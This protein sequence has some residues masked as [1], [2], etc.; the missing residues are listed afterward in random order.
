M[1]ACIR[2][3]DGVVNHSGNRHL[4]DIVERAQAVDLGRRNAFRSAL[5]LAALGFM[6]V[7]IAGC[8]G[9]ETSATVAS[10]ATTGALPKGPSMSG[11]KAVATSTGDTVVVPDGYTAHAIAK[12][13]DPLF[14]NSPEWRGD[15]SEDSQAQELQVGDNHDGIQYIGL[16]GED[17]KPRSDAGLLVINHEYV[18][19]EYLYAPGDDAANWLEP[20]TPDKARKGQAAHGLTVVE[21]RLDASG[22]WHTVLDSKYN[23]RIT[24]FSPMVVTGPAAGNPMLMTADDPTGMAVKGT[25]NNCGSG[26]TPWHTVLTAE[27]NFN[28]YFGTKD[29][30][31]KPDVLQGR[32]GVTAN[33]FGYRWHEVDD[34]FD[35]AI[36]PNEP[37]RFGWIVEVDPMQPDQPPKKRTAL[38]RFKHEAAETIIA[39]DGRVVVYMGDDER[40]EYIYKFISS[41]T[42]D[43]SKPETARDV[44][45][46]G[47]LCVARFD[48]DRVSGDGKGRGHW[49]PLIFGQFGLDESN[50][51]KDQ[52]DVLIRTRQA[53]DLR[54]ATMMDRP[55]WIAGNPLRTGEIYITLTN[56]SRRGDDPPSVNAADGT[57]R[58]GSA[59]PPLDEANPRKDNPWGHILRIREDGNDPN[60]LDFEWDLFLLAGNP[61]KYA[62]PDPRAGSANIT[63][64]NMFNSPDGL[65]FDSDGRLWIQSDGSFSNTG[66]FEGMGNNQ[67][68]VADPFSGEVKRFAV[69]PAGCEITGITF[70]PDLKTMFFDVQ[71]PGELGSHPNKPDGFGDNDIARQ[72]DAF[73]KF[74]NEQD[75][76][77]PG[78]QSRPRSATIVVRRKDGG[79]IGA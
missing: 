70:T 36:N 50:G 24:G 4:T 29:E 5:G 28:G 31:W 74:P 38:G 45:D 67:M 73:S 52:A 3:D 20:F 13:G 51:F 17:G 78:S 26:R 57:T 44:L 56:N 6:G 55:E 14:P 68:L 64:D 30:N 71:H 76:T 12:W 25:L 34:R 2:D 66:D 54:G 47:T 77:L 61:V 49:L 15:A 48:D 33:G 27:E 35:V 63:P 32:Y 41:R 43:P 7:P 69:G 46:H 23:R 37:N 1:A 75:A 58:A 72:A 39:G 42:I 10:D 60:S 40:N 8:G 53:A 62:K 16:P 65:Q 9:S 79:V 19:P 22:R 18:N 59:N 21:V 11:W